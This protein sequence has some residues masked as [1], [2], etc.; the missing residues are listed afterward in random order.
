MA[1][2]EEFKN[3]VKHNPSFAKYVNDGKMTWQKFY[4]MY[5]LYG[6]DNPIWDTY[7]SREENTTQ[8]L[9]DIIKNIDIDAI[10]K[11]ITSA[12]KA[13]DFV[14]ELTGKTSNVTP[15]VIT[16]RPLNKFFED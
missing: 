8:G 5:D 15:E 10:K 13:L 9:N 1:N 11:H 2:K 14:Q 4:E 3:F 12:Q 16:P 6:S 7:Q